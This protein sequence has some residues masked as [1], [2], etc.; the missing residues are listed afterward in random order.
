MRKRNIALLAFIMV[1][2][3]VGCGSK[4]NK[5][6]GTWIVDSVEMDGTKFSAS[7][8]EA[9]GSND[10]ASKT[11]MVLKDGGKAYFAEGG[12]DGVIVDW[13]ETTDGKILV[14]GV[15]CTINDGLIRM[16]AYD[17]EVIYFKKSSDSQTIEQPSD[18]VI[19]ESTSNETETKETVPEETV[20]IKQSPDKYTWYIKNYVG[21][22]CASIGYTSMGGDRMDHYGAGYI[23]L[24]LV[25]PDG[26]YIDIETD[27]DL[28]QYVVTAQSIAPNTELKYTFEKDDEGNEFESLVSWQNYEEIVLCVKK[29]GSSEETSL[30]LTEI[31]SSPDKYTW[32]IRDYTGRNLASCGYLSLG[33]NRMDHY[34][35]GYIKF[36]IVS[37]DGT[38]I[39]PEDTDLLKNYVITGQNIAP[40][41]ELKF[42]FAMDSEGNEYENLVD[43][44]S[45]E[46]IDLT[47]K[48]IH[49]E[50]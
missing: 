27:D 42:V 32:Y 50:S 35:A 41:T 25:T 20:T 6:T 18:K 22:N 47:V 38:F 34:G 36:V 3:L 21:K 37:E 7:E 44:Q 14:D 24:V 26:A 8:L 9:I 45:I 29:I 13:Y 49:S 15:V 5:L 2:F 12:V 17:D 28:K 4:T 19:E 10:W 16:E 40:N 31:I 48:L 46:E 43:S 23:E 39:D 1:L 33:G 30:G 11:L